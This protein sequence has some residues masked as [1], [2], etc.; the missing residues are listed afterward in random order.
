MKRLISF[1]TAASVA[2]LLLCTAPS[3]HATYPGPNGRILFA[4]VAP[5]DFAGILYA[6][7]PDG[8]HVVRVSRVPGFCSEWSPDGTRIAYTR[9]EP[10]GSSE[11]ATIDPDG[12][13][14]TLVGAGE[15]PSWSPDGTRLV[16]DI[17]NGL[18]PSSPDFSTELWVMHADGSHP[19]PLMPPR[20][21]GFDVEPRWSPSGDLVTFARIRKF[22]LGI[23]QEAVFT[24]RT[25]GTDLRQLTSMGLA[26]EHPT[27]SPNGRWIVFN[28]ASYKPGMHETIWVM[29][30]DG[31]DRHVVYQGTSNT[32]GVKP[33]FSPDG[34]KIVFACIS[35]GSAFGRGATGDICTINADGTGLTDITNTPSDFE[36][37]PTWGTAPLL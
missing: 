1:T 4:K 27:W 23:Q 18:D 8:S 16:F 28:D 15:C 33:H 31:S 26:P 12:T 21:Q 19:H 3:A 6:A 7:N 37:H 11:I 17:G 13:D 30:A 34:R 25:D 29:R 36:N 32:G 35:Y 14:E 24:V 2:A 22:S 5:G 10:D 9:I 20:L